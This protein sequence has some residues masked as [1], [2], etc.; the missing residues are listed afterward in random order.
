MAR[1]FKLLSSQI[2]VRTTKP[3]MLIQA[4]YK[5]IRKEIRHL[6]IILSENPMKKLLSVA[7]QKQENKTVIL[8]QQRSP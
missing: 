7:Y 6:K 2:I 4:G 8:F 3:R 5:T 1:G